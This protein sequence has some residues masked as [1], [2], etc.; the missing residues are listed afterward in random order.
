MSSDRTI[1]VYSTN[2]KHSA[3]A[4]LLNIFHCIRDIVVFMETLDFYLI[5]ID[6]HID[7]RA[8]KENLVIFRLCDAYLIHILCHRMAG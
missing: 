2:L 5:H 6:L 1:Y 8:V 4:Q 3:C 7:L